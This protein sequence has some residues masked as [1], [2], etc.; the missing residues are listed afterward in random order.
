[1][2]SRTNLQTTFTVLRKGAERSKAVIGKSAT[3]PKIV[4]IEKYPSFVRYLNRAR[5]AL[6]HVP[7]ARS[8]SDS[9]FKS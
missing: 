6:S 8:A 1:M 3:F 4:D 2:I 7:I 9:H 5:K